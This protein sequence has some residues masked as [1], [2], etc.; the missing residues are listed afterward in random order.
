M[1]SGEV[2]TSRSTRKSRRT[3]ATTAHRA[4]ARGGDGAFGLLIRDAAS[5]PRHYAAEPGSDK[6]PLRAGQR[7]PGLA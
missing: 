3:W 6:A 7:R 4:W 5:T 2:A 1:L